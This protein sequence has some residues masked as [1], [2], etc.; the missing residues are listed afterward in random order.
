MYPCVQ[1]NGTNLVRIIPYSVRSFYPPH[2]EAGLDPHSLRHDPHLS[3][4]GRMCTVSGP[5]G[6]CAQSSV[7]WGN[8]HS[9]RSLGGMCTVSGPSGECAQSSGPRPVVSV[10]AATRLHHVATA[11]QKRR[12]LL[13]IAALIL[14]DGK[15]RLAYHQSSQSTC[16]GNVALTAARR[17]DH[18]QQPRA[19]IG[20]ASA[21]DVSWGRGG[22]AF[23]LKEISCEQQCVLDNLLETK[24]FPGGICCF[25]RCSFQPTTSTSASL[26]TKLAS[27]RFLNGC[28]Q[29]CARCVF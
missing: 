21:H 12:S 18:Y 28:W 20:S 25:S 5:S 22:C 10:S 6:E 11:H 14:D 15:C 26:R 13:L 4:L 23:S 17:R 27:F 2:A 29:V 7:P 16:C 8:V 24:Y 3:A 19:W 9:H 1:G